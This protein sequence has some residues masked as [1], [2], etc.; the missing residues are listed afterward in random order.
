MKFLLL[1]LTIILSFQLKAQ[2][3]KFKI[4]G[5]NDTTIFLA[6]YLG[7]RLYYADTSYS[8]NG[9]IEFNKKDYKGGVYALICPGPK[10]FEFIMADEQIEMETS[11]NSFIASMKVKKSIENKI[12]YDYIQFINKKKKEAEILKKEKGNDALTAID[13]EVKSYQKKI[14]TEN[15]DRLIGKILNMSIDPVIPEELQSNDTLKY[16]FYVTHFWDNIDLTDPRLVHSPVYH[17]KLN[18]FF[19][20]LLIQHPDTICKHA[21]NV[22]NQ[23]NKESD[24]FKYTVHFITYNFETSK[25]MGMDAV[26]VCMAQNYY[27]PADSSDAFWLKKE[28][29]VE[30]CDKANALEPLLI[31]KYA[32][33]VIL[34][35]TSEKKWIDFYQLPQKYNLL[36]FWDPDCGHCKKEMPK[37]K[38]LYADLKEK[39]VD[40]E[41]IGI[42]TNLENEKWKKFVLENELKWLN[43][44]DFPE[45]NENPRK[46][47]Y[48][49][50]VTDLKSLNFRKTY[51]IFST[52]QIYLLDQDK[53]II[54]K[55]LDA[56]TF[57]D[58][59]QKIEKIK[60]PYVEVL[61]EEKEKKEKEKEKTK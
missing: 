50:R 42:G 22:I 17:N 59:L 57:G 20:K 14:V 9:I 26:F 60:L 32:P 11:I 7:D 33:R 34:A 5:L 37:L 29:L 19:K 44:S 39:N 3:L 47:L 25:I 10:Y 30:L 4:N 13:K 45:A 48:E 49:L 1:S 21:Q 18:Y 52:P 31:G 15:K 27:C 41:F 40:I 38:K 54:G 12:F 35:D 61:K 58:L 36:I 46:F 2:Q 51:D 8:K 6:R 23:L 24:I 53:K 43:I 56:L 55:K 28:K 16:Q